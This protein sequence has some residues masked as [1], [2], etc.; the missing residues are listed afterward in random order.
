MQDKRKL[1][2]AGSIIFVVVMFAQAFIRDTFKSKTV[3][4]SKNT[5]TQQVVDDYA[6]WGLFRNGYALPVPPKWQNTSDTGGVAILEPGEQVGSLNQISIMVLSDKNAP[7]GQQF[8]TQKELDEWTAVSGP[9]QGDVQKTNNITLG[10][11][12]GVMF[13]DTTGEKDAWLAMAWTRKDGINVQIRFTGTGE[14]TDLDAKTVDY[15]VSNFTFT[16]PPI[17][18][19]E[20]K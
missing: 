8:T 18:G 19:K 2:L 4:P 9:V 15:I 10:G 1:L 7:Q 11:S 6:N 12:P 20:G 5:P 14:Y 16:P 17:T 3:T 13:L